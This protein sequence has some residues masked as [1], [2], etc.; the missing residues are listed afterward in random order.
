MARQL[1]RRRRTD[2]ASGGLRIAADTHGSPSLGRGGRRSILPPLPR[3]ATRP[4]FRSIGRKPTVALCNVMLATR[5]SF[6]PSERSAAWRVPF[7]T[8]RARCGCACPRFR[9]SERRVRAHVFLA[10]PHVLLDGLLRRVAVRKGVSVSQEERPRRPASKGVQI[11]SALARC[12]EG[13]RHGF[14]R[15]GVPTI[16]RNGNIER[17]AGHTAYRIDAQEVRGVSQSVSQYGDAG[18]A[19]DCGSD[20]RPAFFASRRIPPPNGCRPAGTGSRRR[21]SVRAFPDAAAQPVFRRAASPRRPLSSSLTSARTLRAI[22][23]FSG[24]SAAANAGSIRV[25]R[26]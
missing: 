14:L 10:A 7:E 1:R 6:A 16:F 18:P 8:S 20:S 3:C 25:E 26:A 21:R 19:R 9:W 12:R 13:Y 15:P 23:G 24:G 5:T 2:R 11:A 4:K 22:A 17:T